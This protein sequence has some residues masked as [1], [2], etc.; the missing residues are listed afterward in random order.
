MKL[1]KLVPDDTN[2]K[3]LRWRVPFYIVSVVLMILSWVAVFT[4]G[5]NY[6]VDFAGGQEVRLT[7]QQQNEAPIP[8][9][10]DLVGDLGYG[11]PVVQEFGQPNQVSIRVPL[12]EDVENTPGAA[13]EIGNKVIAAIDQ[14]YPDA[15]T[16][17]NDTVSGKVA[18]EF[19]ER[20]LWALLA[21]M[22][23]I[24]I[25]IWVRFEWQFGVGALFALVHD[26]SL[27]MGFFAITQ[28]EFSLQIIAAILAIIG[29]SLNDTIVVYDRIRENLKK[30]RKMPVP[31][32]LDLSVN[33]TL[34]RTIMTSLTLLVALIP[35]L[36]FGPASLFGMVAA[37]TLGIF[38]GTYS[39][40]YMAAPILIWMGVTGSSFV[41]QESK[42]DQ[43]EKVARGEA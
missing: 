33:E 13:T 35:L 6:G 4:M 36:L 24:A 3:F 7:F 34:A 9:L 29:Y 16:D 28:L 21:A 15:R 22:A 43:Q 25:Y 20:A 26:V 30:F 11:E 2:I 37:I 19:R 17:G 1:L 23:A 8:Q 10:R 5:L 42:A 38:I 27:T 40:I 18:G 41:P 39:S 14:Q 12:P 32:L 31:E